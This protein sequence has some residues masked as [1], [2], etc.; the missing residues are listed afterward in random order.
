[1]KDQTYHIDLT[2]E[3]AQLFQEETKKQPKKPSSGSIF[4]IVAGVHAVGLVALITTSFATPA[5][6]KQENLLSETNTPAPQ[7]QKPAPSPT[8]LVASP[9]KLPTA[10]KPDTATS[11]K[12]EASTPKETNP[13]FTKTYTI[14]QGDTINSISKQYKLNTARLL[15]INN[16]K[17]PNKIVV[18]QTLKFL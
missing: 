10:A 14:K 7:E 3:E 1:M 4:W 9:S 17:D 18:G 5:K 11:P 6:P 2:P 12:V 15:K 8:P 13:K 16:I